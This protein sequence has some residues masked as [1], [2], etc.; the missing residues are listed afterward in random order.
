[1]AKIYAQD[2][3]QGTYATLRMVVR[4]PQFRSGYRDYL[5]GRPPPRFFYDDTLKRAEDTWGY[6][7]GR[8]VAAWLLANGQRPPPLKEIPAL[9]AAYL[10]AEDADVVL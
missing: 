6:E 2:N 7:R 1:V 4:D 3:Q 9:V 5:A 10:A 8:L